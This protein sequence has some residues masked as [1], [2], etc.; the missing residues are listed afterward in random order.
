MIR[1]EKRTSCGQLVA[2][3]AADRANVE[4]EG[5]DM[6]LLDSGA[7]QGKIYSDG[8]REGSGGEHAVIE[9]A[10]GAKLG[11]IGY[12]TPS[13]VRRAARR[14]KE[15]QRGWA[16]QSYTERAAV[17]RRA[18]DLWNAHADEIKTWLTRETGAIPPMGDLQV[19]LSAEECY[20]AAAMASQPYGELLRTEQPRL[21]MASIM[22][23]PRS[24]VDANAVPRATSSGACTTPSR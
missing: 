9:P 17:L 11:R 3:R 22:S 7:W 24:V 14:A 10:T 13:D 8:W 6:G 2:W 15:A 20:E 1:Q 5:R 16:A 12:A 4:R 19:H 21:S 23:S 18:G